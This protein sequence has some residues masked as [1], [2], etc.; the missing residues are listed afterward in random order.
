MGRIVNRTWSRGLT[1]VAAVALAT[2]AVVIGCA[3]NEPTVGTGGEHASVGDVRPDALEVRTVEPPVAAADPGLPYEPVPPVIPP[4]AKPPAKAVEA[5]VTQTPV[6]KAKTA[7]A[8]VVPAMDTAEPTPRV[9]GT[10]HVVR[11]GE[12]LTAI[13]KAE[14][15]DGRKWKKIAA[16][17][18]SVASGALK[19]GQT[20]IVP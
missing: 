4:R 9:G 15:G 20:L 17:N 6:G 16:A 13:A 7:G 5:F 1:V 18:P 14:Y 2:G 19:I 3:N 10:T 8:K 11:K 12:T